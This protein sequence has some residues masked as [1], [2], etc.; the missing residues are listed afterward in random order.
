MAEDSITVFDR[1][2]LRMRRDRVAGT[3][4]DH[5]FLLREVCERLAD[6]LLDVRRQFPLALD[7]GCHCGELAELLNGRGGIETLLQSDISSR[8][9]R[10]AAA[11]GHQ[12]VVADEEMMPFADGA[13]DLVLSALSLH[14]VNDLP[15]ALLQAHRAL[16]PDGLFLAAMLGG[17][18]LY[19][20]RAVLTQ[21]ESEIVGGVNPRV[22]PVVEL[23][24]AAGLMQRAGFALPV[25]DS[26]TITVHYKNPLR[27]LTDLRAM[28]ESSV[29]ADRS[30]RPLRRDVVMRALEIYSDRFA[31]P[32]G[33][34]PATF[35]VIFLTG[36]RPHSSQPQ[37]L[38]PGSAEA[39]L[40]EALDTKEKPAGDKA[41]PNPTGPR[42]R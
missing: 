21:A 1:R 7:L 32:D 40:A 5:D 13:F 26:D 23:R 37:P 25:A 8:M 3:Y 22:S 29:L 41:A 11:N 6:R 27:L 30:R 39:R 10:A 36:W 34:V 38:R 17:E 4:G 9:A 20:L 14:W 28:G 42:R 16:K 31:R 33:R 2:L 35:Q 18:T 19:E 12:A 15:G 24:E